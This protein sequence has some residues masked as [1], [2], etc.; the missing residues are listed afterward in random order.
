MILTFGIRLS[1]MRT[2]T[3]ILSPGDVPKI[4]PELD[5]ATWMSTVIASADAKGLK[6]ELSKQLEKYLENPPEEKQKKGK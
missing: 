4:I 1:T 3:P 5:F 2:V 6:F